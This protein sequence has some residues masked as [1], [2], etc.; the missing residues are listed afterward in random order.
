METSERFEQEV[1]ALRMEVAELRR[2]VLRHV[3]DKAQHPGPK[4][5]PTNGPLGHVYRS[6]AELERLLAA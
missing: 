2:L 1:A 6:V 5:G 4:P 3:T